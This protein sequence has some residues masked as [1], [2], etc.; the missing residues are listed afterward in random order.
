M[1]ALQQS[2]APPIPVYPSTL[3]STVTEYNPT[4]SPQGSEYDQ[5]LNHQS[6]GF[7]YQTQVIPVSPTYPPNPPFSAPVAPALP[8]SHSFAAPGSAPLAPAPSPQ[9]YCTQYSNSPNISNTPSYTPLPLFA[10]ENSFSP[11]ALS[12]GLLSVPN[13]VSNNPCV[14]NLQNPTGSPA[15]PTFAQVSATHSFTPLMSTHHT[16]PIPYSAQNGQYSAP[17]PFSSPIPAHS[18]TRNVTNP[19][20]FKR[21]L[22]SPTTPQTARPPPRPRPMIAQHFITSTPPPP[23]RGSSSNVPVTTSQQRSHYSRENNGQ[24]YNH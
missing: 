19:P 17:P 11:D 3:P 2:V 21:P 16:S 23:I 20:V 8:P 5:T 15:V 24:F 9:Q 1:P 6:S 7:Y 22:S 12:P 10:Q 18:G 13:T 14:S 4:Q